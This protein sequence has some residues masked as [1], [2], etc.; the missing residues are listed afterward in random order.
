MKRWIA[1]FA[2][3]VAL[4]VVCFVSY[5][6][7]NRAPFLAT[8]LSHALDT[9]VKVQSI[10]LSKQGLQIRNLSIKNPP[11]CDV[12]NA[13][14]VD[15]INVKM[16]WWPLFK[17]LVGL[18]AE[19]IIIDQIKIEKPE[20][21]VELF[22]TTGSDSNWSRILAKVSNRAQQQKTPTG[23]RHFAIGKLT[24]N[25]VKFQLTHHS[26]PQLS[27]QP[28][29]VDKME[30]RDIGMNNDVALRD[31]ALNVCM[32]LVQEASKQFALNQMSPEKVMKNLLNTDN[33]SLQQAG[34]ILKGF[35]QK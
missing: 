25:E 26:L 29:I 19:K 18:S 24:I 28:I 14:S 15:K 1:F 12:K 5:V 8:A 23:E 27:V 32:V 6:Y 20:M 30:I 3:F 4:I 10:D 34:E 13:F 11:G 16:N 31:I 9:E 2:L 22:N 17:G 7:I 21:S 35:F 33:P